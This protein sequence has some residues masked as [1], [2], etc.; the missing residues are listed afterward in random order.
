MTD[1]INRKHAL[2]QMN[3]NE[4]E[5]L[6]NEMILSEDE[7]AVFELIYIKRKPLTYIADITGYSESGIKKMHQ[8]ILKRINIHENRH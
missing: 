8:R 5:N 1:H 4:I 6:L 3:R 7:R 2:M